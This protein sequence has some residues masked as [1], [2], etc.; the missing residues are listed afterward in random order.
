MFEKQEK[1]HKFYMKIYKCN[2]DF[3]SKIRYDKICYFI[4]VQSL[5]EADLQT[6]AEWLC[7]F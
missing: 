4:T 7:Y 5:K 1:R 2:I 3:I 6:E